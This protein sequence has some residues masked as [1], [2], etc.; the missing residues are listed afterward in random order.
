MQKRNINA[1]DSRRNVGKWVGKQGGTSSCQRVCAFNRP[2]TNEAIRPGK[3]EGEEASRQ[4]G[5]PIGK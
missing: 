4:A 2:G 1:N 3:L 5:M